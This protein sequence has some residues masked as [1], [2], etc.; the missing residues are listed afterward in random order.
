M[1]RMTGIVAVALGSLALLAFVAGVAYATDGKALYD[2][3]CAKCHG[4]DGRADTPVG[5]AM[6]TASLVDPEWT[7]EDAAAAL[8]SAFRENPKHKA[9]HGKVSD[10][11]L[12]A[13]AAHVRELAAAA[14]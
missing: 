9:V 7:S 13:I 11:D 2:A 1:R 5:K 10:D 8:V 6:K 3:N 14:E 4:A 12:T